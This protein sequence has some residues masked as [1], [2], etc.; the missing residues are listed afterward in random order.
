MSIAKIH[1]VYGKLPDSK[2][3]KLVGRI[4]TIANKPHVLE[5]WWGVLSDKSPHEYGH[6]NHWQEKLKDAQVLID[7]PLEQEQNGYQLPP[8]ALEVYEYHHPEE[9]RQGHFYVH[10]GQV[11]DSGKPMSAFDMWNMQQNIANGGILLTP[12]EQSLQKNEDELL[13]PHQNHGVARNIVE[14]LKQSGMPFDQIHQAHEMLF[15]DAMTPEIGNRLAYEQ[16]MLQPKNG[17][18]MVIDANGFGHINEAYGFEAGDEAIRALAKSIENALSVS[19]LHRSAAAHRIGGDEFHVFVPNLGDAKNFLGSL[20]NG[21][22]AAQKPHPE[23]GL[24]VSVGLGANPHSAY[25]AMNEEA[26]KQKTQD[27]SRLIGSSSQKL[28][29]PKAV[30]AF[31]NVGNQYGTFEF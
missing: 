1:F 12:K 26:K 22:K 4:A 23:Y 17:I 2:H 6:K 14:Y 21:L 7:P 29:A 3:H 30:Y 9:K 28:Q 16:F 5:D 8:D 24:S 25:Q 15:H 20:E 11:W 27:I 13:K 31:S 10:Q 18:H 19:G